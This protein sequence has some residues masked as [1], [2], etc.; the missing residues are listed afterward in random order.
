MED[1]EKE[2]HRELE[3]LPE[4]EAPSTL[5]PAV[6]DRI[7]A[8][9]PS[10][11]YHASWW[12]WPLVVRAAS[13]VLALTVLCALGW[14]SGFFGD[15]GFGQ[16]VIRACVGL[17]DTCVVALET[18]ERAFGL[19]AVFWRDHGQMI[20]GAAAALLLG[21]YLICVAAGTALYQL[22]WRKSYER[23]A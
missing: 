9:A 3:A 15:W 20:L 6:M 22:A 5:I 16:Q 8:P 11:W 17:K 10:P 7:T 2:L 14:L 12:Q 21:T 4:L 18:G 23:T 1:W 13:V 19:G